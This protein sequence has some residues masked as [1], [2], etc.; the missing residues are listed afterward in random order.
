MYMDM[1]ACTC[2]YLFKCV[3]HMYAWIYVYVYVCLSAD[4]KFLRNE[5][6]TTFLE[7]LLYTIYFFSSSSS[8]SSSSS[9]PRLLLVLLRILVLSTPSNTFFC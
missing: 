4:E 1:Y 5:V 7:I 8:T 2:A 6:L 3:I 9:P